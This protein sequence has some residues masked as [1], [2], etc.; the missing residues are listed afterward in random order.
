[1]E[2]YDLGRDNP[3]PLTESRSLDKGCLAALVG[4]PDKRN[5]QAEGF[6]RVSDSPNHHASH[7]KP[8]EISVTESHTKAN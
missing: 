5:D 7:G 1:M 6:I 4:M 2:A 8:R 3:G